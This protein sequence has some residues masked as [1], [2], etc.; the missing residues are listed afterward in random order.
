MSVSLTVKTALHVTD[1]TGDVMTVDELQ[2][3]TIDDNGSAVHWAVR[4]GSGHDAGTLW[5]SNHELR[6]LGDHLCRMADA[7]ENTLNNVEKSVS[8]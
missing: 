6:S 3:P 4:C 7:M 8:V 1:A 2:A 5:L